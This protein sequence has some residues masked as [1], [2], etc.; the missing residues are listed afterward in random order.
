MGPATGKLA[1]TPAEHG[2]QEA[3][4]ST[5]ARRPE[6]PGDSP[7]AAGQAGAVAY[8]VVLVDLEA[9]AQVQGSVSSAE[10]SSSKI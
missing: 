8:P 10:R 9:A 6:P 5:S 4:A 3:K 7:E 2:G 1:Q